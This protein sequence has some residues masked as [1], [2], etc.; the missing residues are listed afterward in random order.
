VVFQMASVRT[1]FDEPHHRS[2]ELLAAQALTQNDAATAFRLADRCCRISPRPDPHSYLLR[3]DAFFRLGET[4][5]ALSDVAN[6]LQ[7][8]PE[9][10]GANRRMLAWANGL[11]QSTAAAVLIS[12]DRDV[13]TLRTAIEVL[14]RDRQC[15]FASVAVLDDVIEGWAVWEDEALLEVTITEGADRTIVRLEPD[16]AHAL[17]DFGRALSFRLPRPASPRPQ[18]IVLSVADRVFYSTRT[19]SRDHGPAARSHRLPVDAVRARGATVVVPVYGDYDATRACLESLLSELQSGSRHRAIVVN[20]ATPD[21]RIAEYLVSVAAKP[22]IQLLMNARNLGFVGAVNRALREI[23]DGDVVLLNADTIVPRGFIDR[24]AAAARSSPD[25]GTVMPLSNNGDLAGFPVPH[26]A[27]PLGSIDDV[28]RID[29]VAAAVNAGCVIDIPN[30]VGFCLYLTRTCL[31]AVG[32]LSEDFDRGY[33]EDVDFCLRARMRGFRNVCAPSVYVGHAGSKSFAAEKPSLVVRNMDVLLYRYPNYRLEFGAFDLADPLRPYRESIERAHPPANRPRLLIAGTGAVGAIARARGRKLASEGQAVLILEV[34]HRTGGPR[35]MIADPTGG[36]PQS[37][38]F[39]LASP[40]DRDLLLAYARKVRPS[41]IEILDPARVPFRL[42]DLL[43]ELQVPYD[44]VVAD[45]GL[46]GRSD[47]AALLAATRCVCS[48]DDGGRRDSAHPPDLEALVRRWRVVADGAEKI[49]AAG[50]QAMAFAAGLFAGRRIDG[51]EETGPKR[52]RSPPCS[53]KKATGCRLGLVPVRA[54]AQE[55]WLMMEIAHALADA[56][57]DVT[58]T[59]I[60]ATLDDF[61]LMRIGNTHVTGA[62]HDADLEQVAESH[63]L[64]VLFASVTQPLFGHPLLSAAF[65]SSRPLAY[66]DWSMGRVEPT[67]GDLPLDPNLTLEAIV[68]KLKRW[69]PV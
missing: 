35:I 23:A 50:E 24:L 38:Q 59:V 30:G 68:A 37:I 26:L 3:S 55:Q 31:D 40:T 4:S 33:L 54:C 7:I 8:A 25:I 44:M 43:R 32:F 1:I 21:P 52:S 6:A 62:V 69:I 34:R 56:R 22:R 61:S 27:G 46:L 65:N 10:V 41:R 16:P 5:A 12:R 19:S 66:F 20:D 13:A 51:I 48:Y 39:D 42:V 36:V 64:D 17:H 53:Q 49:L 47:A 18:S 14:R 63:R 60:G 15:N 57:P 29:K 9:D 67:K 2:L 11:Q 45:A 58:V 28:E